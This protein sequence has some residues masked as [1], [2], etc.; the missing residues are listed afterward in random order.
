MVFGERV[1]EH[2]HRKVVMLQAL[3]DAL[4][5]HTDAL[6]E[7]I[8]GNGVLVDG[9]DIAHVV[10]FGEDVGEGGHLIHLH[11]QLEPTSSHEVLYS[12]P[13]QLH[14]IAHESLGVFQFVFR[15]VDDELLACLCVG[16]LISDVALGSNELRERGLVVDKIEQYALFHVIDMVFQPA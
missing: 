10:A 15:D 1:D 13:C 9:I 7:G 6:I 2:R 12:S 5:E 4:L 11:G 3:A 16:I 14:I 8:G